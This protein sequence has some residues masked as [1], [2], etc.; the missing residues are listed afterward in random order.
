MAIQISGTTVIDNSRNIVNASIAAPLVNSGQLAAA[1][2]GTGTAQSGNFLRGDLTWATV[3]G[4]SGTFSGS[5]VLTSGTSYT[6]P[7]T[8]TR[9]YVECVGGGGGGGCGQS[10]TPGG[11]GA[12]GGY[13]AS[14]F[15]VSGG[16][17][18][19]YAIGAA[20]AACPSGFNT[21]GQSGGAT[22]FTVG[23]TQL[24]AGGGQAGG[25]APAPNTTGGSASGGS[26]N[27]TGGTG[28]AGPVRVPGTTY[29]GGIQSSGGG[30][31]GQPIAPVPVMGGTP[32][33]SG[34]A[35]LIRVWE[36]T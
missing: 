25:A 34:V 4:V 15:P 7:P 22:T 16:T 29:F 5:T 6:T 36:F 17:A 33:Q 35:G 28:L 21:A 14:Y 13:C 19:S 23:A 24:S 3:S 12:G 30:G 20:G 9:I 10:G 8:T 26:I 32:G 27:V 31:Q 1:R 2:L 18:Y 11:S